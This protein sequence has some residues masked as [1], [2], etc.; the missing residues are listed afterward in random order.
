[1]EQVKL[2]KKREPE[3]K[4][5]RRKKSAHLGAGLNAFPLPTSISLHILHNSLS[6]PL[7]VG[8]MHVPHHLHIMQ[9]RQSSQGI[10]IIC[11]GQYTVAGPVGRVD[12]NVEIEFR[13]GLGGS[14]ERGPGLR[15]GV[16]VEWD[17]DEWPGGVWGHRGWDEEVV[18]RISSTARGWMRGSSHRGASSS[19]VSV[20]DCQ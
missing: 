20:V 7:T 14:V 4:K 1:M 17:E 13:V 10:S 9:S 19:E 2:N 3:K 16:D 5:K 11:I 12:D 18:E 6:R 15:R 8:A